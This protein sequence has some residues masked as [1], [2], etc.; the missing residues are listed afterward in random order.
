VTYASPYDIEATYDEV[1]YILGSGIWFARVEEEGLRYW[2]I[3]I[4]NEGQ[5]EF[6]ITM[7]EDNK[8]EVYLIGPRIICNEIEAALRENNE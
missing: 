2:G 6:E 1:Q 7:N 8:V 4:F 5:I 3:K